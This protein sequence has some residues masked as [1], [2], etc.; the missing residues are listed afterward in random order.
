LTSSIGRKWP[1]A[2]NPPHGDSHRR[3]RGIDA[4]LA[5]RPRVD[6]V[7]RLHLHRWTGRP[8]SVPPTDQVAV[9]LLG[10][11]RIPDSGI[12]GTRGLGRRQAASRAGRR[13]GLS[14]S[15]CCRCNATSRRP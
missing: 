15:F 1:R 10:D 3:R 8:S 7:V 2:R 5:R 11:S 14:A 4:V 9:D 6:R 13:P 12:V